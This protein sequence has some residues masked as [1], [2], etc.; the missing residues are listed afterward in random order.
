MPALDFSQILPRES[1][2]MLQRRGVAAW[3]G[4]NAGVMVVFCIVF[5]V[6]V[7]LLGLLISKKLAARRE[8]RERMNAHK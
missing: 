7:V 8:R 2:R 5:V 3:P 1:S 6:A 4:Q